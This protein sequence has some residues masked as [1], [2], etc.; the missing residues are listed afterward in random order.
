MI[1]NQTFQLSID[2]MDNFEEK[3][4]IKKYRH[5]KNKILKLKNSPLELENDFKP[6]LSIIYRRY[7]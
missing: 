7:G 5:K 3:E 6:N 1:L 4:I 2:D